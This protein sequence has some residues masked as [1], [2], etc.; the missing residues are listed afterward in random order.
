MN[1]RHLSI[2]LFAAAVLFTSAAASAQYYSPGTAVT[3]TH[4]QAMRA[5]NMGD[6]RTAYSLFSEMAQR[7]DPDGLFHL[8]MMHQNGEGVPRDL[9]EAYSRLYLAGRQGHQGAAQQ[10]RNLQA[11]MPPA[12]VAAARSRIDGQRGQP[13]A[14]PRANGPRPLPGSR[15]VRPYRPPV[16]TPPIRPD[17]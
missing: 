10:A 6:Y 17:N 14:R 15:V 2:S 4:D 7:G 12:D 9:R 8:G 16:S 1:T 3:S 5:L 11:S 13:A